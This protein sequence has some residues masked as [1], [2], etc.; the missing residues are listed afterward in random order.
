MST[1]SKS[2]NI[3]KTSKKWGPDNDPID[4]APVWHETMGKHYLRNI[5]YI[6]CIEESNKDKEKQYYIVFEKNKKSM[7]PQLIHT[8][9]GIPKYILELYGTD[10]YPVV[11]TKTEQGW[12]YLIP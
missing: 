6:K 2:V 4:R 3:K 10:P 9:E 11:V 12:E 1:V 8:P 5:Y 7:W